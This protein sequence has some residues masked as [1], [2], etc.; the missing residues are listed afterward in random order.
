MI[1]TYCECVFVALG[2][3][4]AMPMRHIVICG[5]HRSTIFFHIITQTTRIKKKKKKILSTSNSEHTEA[6]SF[7]HFCCGRAMSVTY[8]ECVFVALGIRHAMG[9]RHIFR[10][11]NVF[12]HKMCILIFSTNFV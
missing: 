8:C 12:G 5:L 11:K 1:I 10:K 9:M 2:I 6:R 4:H 3:Q 7:K